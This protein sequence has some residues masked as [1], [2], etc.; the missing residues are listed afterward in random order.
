[1]CPSSAARLSAGLAPDQRSERRLCRRNDGG[2]SGGSSETPPK[3]LAGTAGSPPEAPAVGL[4]GARASYEVGCRFQ[5]TMAYVRC[6]K[7]PLT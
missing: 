1:V 2:G 6:Q 7:A 3:E 4:R 5:R